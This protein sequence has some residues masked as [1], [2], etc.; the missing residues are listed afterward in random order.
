M[1]AVP[2]ISVAL[3]IVLDPPVQAYVTPTPPVD[4]AASVIALFTHTGFG[5]TVA[6]NTDGNTFTTSGLV[7]AVDVKQP[8]ADAVTV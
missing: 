1:P 5:L 3:F 7:T 2:L 4:V 8:G 6:V